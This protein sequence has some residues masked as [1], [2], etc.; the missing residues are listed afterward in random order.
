MSV[1]LLRPRPRKG[2]ALAL[3]I[4]SSPSSLAP[5]R[6]QAP[7]NEQT[8][9]GT[10]EGVAGLTQAL[11]RLTLQTPQAGAMEQRSKSSDSLNSE[12]RRAVERNHAE[13]K[14]MQDM[15]EEEWQVIFKQGE[16]E[17]LG[18]VGEGIGGS[19]SKARLK[20]SKL[21]FALKTI[22][23]DPDP[24]VHRQILRELSINKGCHSEHIVKYYGAYLSQG[25]ACISICME[26]C[27]GGSLDAV[28][29]RVRETGG[30]IG[31]RVLGKIAEGVLLGLTYL[32][33]KKIIHRDIKPSNILL[34]KSGRVKLCDFGVSGELVNS[35]AGTFTGTSSY[36]APERIQGQPYTVKADVWSLGLTLMEVAQHRFPFYDTNESHAPLMPIEL[37]TIIVTLPVPELKD[38]PEL[39]IKWTQAFRHFLRIWCL[40]SLPLLM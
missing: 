6:T 4:P 14:D 26:F 33:D 36:M 37:L 3:S 29:K 35:L 19:V 40:Y 1:P 24:A 34:T 39:G 21:L 17:E 7:T 12:L 11:P 18:R 5:A 15:N 13:E 31:E 2:P 30:R 22:P 10:E 32:H 27:A 25:S 16:I 20:G 9:E 28:Y 8:D 38:E 23:A